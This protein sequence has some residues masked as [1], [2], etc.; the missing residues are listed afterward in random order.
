MSVIHANPKSVKCDSRGATVE[1]NALPRGWVRVQFWSGSRL[2]SMDCCSQP[3]IDS[4]S[5]SIFA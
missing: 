5:G 3:C 1:F 4:T 2:K